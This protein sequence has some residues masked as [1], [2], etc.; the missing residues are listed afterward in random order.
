MKIIR[1]DAC[2]IANHHVLFEA[3]QGGIRSAGKTGGELLR[4]FGLRR[5]GVDCIRDMPTEISETSRR[6]AFAAVWAR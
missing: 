2:D 5:T 4:V 3:L 6:N 1:T